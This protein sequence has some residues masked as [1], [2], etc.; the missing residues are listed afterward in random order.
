MGTPFFLRRSLFVRS[1]LG[2]PTFQLSNFAK[3]EFLLFNDSIVTN[4][5][6]SS[7]FDLNS[8]SSRNIDSLLDLRPQDFT[9]Q[10][11]MGLSSKADLFPQNYAF[12]F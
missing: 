10:R 4:K 2:V 8:K 11:R 1:F 5:S 3:Y 7:H 9:G 6:R 12:F